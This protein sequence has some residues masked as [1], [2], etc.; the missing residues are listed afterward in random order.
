MERT[1]LSFEL[2]LRK[3]DRAIYERVLAESG[4]KPERIIYVDDIPAYTRAAADLK[5]QVV[6]FESA[7]QLE[8]ALRERGVI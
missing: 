1:F 6:T 7:A 3:P 4:V 5:I 2:G 8:R